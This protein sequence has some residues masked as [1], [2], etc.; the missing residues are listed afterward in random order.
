MAC[1]S[2][3]H[4]HILLYTCQLVYYPLEKVQ[5]ICLRILLSLC[6]DTQG[7]MSAVIFSKGCW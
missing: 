3:N 7:V 4:Y 5:T 6:Y 1:N 2:T